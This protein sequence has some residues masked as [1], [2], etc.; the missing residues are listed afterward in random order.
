MC[1]QPVAPG[2]GSARPAGAGGDRPIQVG[3]H[4]HF[5]E[6]NP[7]LTFDRALSGRPV[8]FHGAGDPREAQAL[9]DLRRCY[10]AAGFR[11]VEFMAEPEA[12]AI[13]SGAAKPSSRSIDTGASS[14]CTASQYHA[15]T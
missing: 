1:G 15:A 5:Y 6:V 12:A 10:L 2:A 7:G 3:S 13:A 9:D 11:E 4:Y 14:S 8:V